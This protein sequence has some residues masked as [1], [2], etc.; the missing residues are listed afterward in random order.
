VS[1]VA[2]CLSLALLYVAAVSASTFAPAQVIQSDRVLVN[3]CG[4]VAVF[5]ACKWVGA[6]VDLPRAVAACGWSEGE[7]IQAGKVIDALSKLGVAC[8]PCK[9]DTERLRAVLGSRRVAVILLTS[10]RAEA[11]MHM[12]TAVAA[13]HSGFLIFDYP[14]LRQQLSAN[15][16]RATWT[17]TCIVVASS[18]T[19]IDSLL[20]VDAANGLRRKPYVVS[21][22]FVALGLAMLA[23]RRRY[24]RMIAV[25]PGTGAES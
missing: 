17:G 2:R 13:D 4:P 5:A 14:C 10:G 12:A 8:R 7:P 3:G 24:S 22:C 25:G 9:L 1:K 11:T 21:A 6:D 18:G 15:Q 16:L 19:E 20:G 23:L